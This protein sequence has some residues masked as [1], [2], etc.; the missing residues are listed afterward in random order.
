MVVLVISTM[1]RVL[2]VSCGENIGVDKDIDRCADNSKW[3]HRGFSLT[4]QTAKYAKMALGVQQAD[5][6]LRIR[7]H[8]LADAL[9][10][11][12][13]LVADVT[14]VQEDLVR[15]RVE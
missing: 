2:N 1:V 10:D 11:D 9:L 3:Y 14:G 12:V 5:D 8:Y 7:A 13:H 6:G 4:E 15:R